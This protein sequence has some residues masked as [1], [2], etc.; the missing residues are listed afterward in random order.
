MRGACIRVL[1][2]SDWNLKIAPVPVSVLFAW[3]LIESDWN[4]KF[5]TTS[6]LNVTFFVLIESDWNLKAFI[7]AAIQFMNF[8]INR[9]RLEFKVYSSFKCSEYPSTVLIE[10]DWNLKCRRTGQKALSCKVLIESDWN[11][12][13]NIPLIV[14]RDNPHVLI[15]SDWNLKMNS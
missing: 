8:C 13:Q 3:V 9:I 15:E 11:L 1:I 6:S 7:L 2:E 4:L 10:S 12:K 14:T 5:M